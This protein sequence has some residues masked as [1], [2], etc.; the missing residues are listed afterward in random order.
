MHGKATIT[1]YIC[2]EQLCLPHNLTHTQKY[3]FLFPPR[4]LII[5]ILKQDVVQPLKLSQKITQCNQIC[6]ETLEIWVQEW[7]QHTRSSS[8]WDL[9]AVK[10]FI[11]G[12]REKFPDLEQFL[13]K[14]KHEIKH[15]TR[16]FFP[17][18]RPLMTSREG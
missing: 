2:I 18:T 6:S 7:K 5:S 13:L 9:D 14:K 10:T 3:L 11:S 4:T 12:E 16:I 17:L 8:L 1:I 15:C